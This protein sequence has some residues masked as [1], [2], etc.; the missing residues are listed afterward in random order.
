MNYPFLIQVRFIELTPYL[1]GGFGLGQLVQHVLWL[2]SFVLR[3]GYCNCRDPCLFADTSIHNI[4]IE[5]IP[6]G[7]SFSQV[8]F[9]LQLFIR[10]AN[11]VWKCEF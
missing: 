2:C 11:H 4:Q 5:D 8:A 1:R 10:N 9:V 7:Y 3:S 6:F